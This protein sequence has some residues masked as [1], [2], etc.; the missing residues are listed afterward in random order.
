MSEYKLNPPTVSFYT[1]NM[2]LKILF[3]HKG[4]SEVFRETSWRSDEIASAFGL[5]EELENDKNLRTVAR[6]LLKARYKTLQ[7]STALL[8]ELWKQAYENLA[9]LAEFLQ[10]NPVEQELLRF[11]M[12]LRSEGPMQ[13]LFDCLPKSDLQRTAAIMADLL[14]QPKNEILSALKKGSKLDAYG[15]IN[16]NYRLD[17]VHDYLAWGETLDFDE[18]VTQPLNEYALLKSCTEI[19]QV[20]SLQL[21][22]FAHIAGMKEMMLTYLQ[23]ALK[24]HQKGVNL[25]IYGVPG[26]GKT[27]FAGLLAQALGISA[28]NIT[29]MDSDGDVVKAEQ[30]LNYS[31]L[32]QTLLNGKQALLIF[33]EIEDVFNGSFMERSVAQ[34]N[35]AWTNQLLENNNVPMI[36]LSNSVHSIDSAFLRRFDFVFEMPDLPLKNKSALISQLAGGKLT[37]KYVQHFAKVRS[38]SP[39][40]LTRVFN[41]ANAVDNG[42]KAFSEV[43]L[44]LFSEA[45]QAQGKKKI[46]PL[47]ESKLSYQLEWV[48]CNENI[49]KISEGLMRTKKGRICC[50]GPPGTGKT[51]WAGWLAEQLDMPLLLCKGSDLLDPYIGG[52]EQKI[53]EAFESAKRDNCL[54]VLDEV[55]SFLFSRDGAERSWERSQVNEML[56]QIERFEGLMVVSTNLMGVLDPAAL[57]RFDLKLKFDYLTPQQRL[58]FAKQQAEK[59]NLGVWDEPHSKRLLELNL[60]TPGDFATVARRH[61]F[62]PFENLEDWLEALCGECRVKP[63]FSRKKVGF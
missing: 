39:A 20:P 56:T 11:A 38:L 42:K 19:P 25:L 37:A 61:N 26:T 55:D 30:R 43:L 8:P 41:V 22:D 3:E 13:D 7:K 47:L 6:R 53:A 23:Q 62:S 10:L 9:T 52:T 4:F 60:L 45:L 5:P 17:S 44:T 35:K 28:Y 63:E 36:W 51:A 50:Y 12:H 24:H 29:Y 2:M 21:D 33:D 32:A 31:R 15:L 1:E 34:K 48:S 58:N 59:L 16:R 57:R 54:L 18:F 14:K 49:H 27:E 46:E 40:I